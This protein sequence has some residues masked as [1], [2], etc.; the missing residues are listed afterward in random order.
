MTLV[1]INNFEAIIVNIFLPIMFKIKRIL[2][3]CILISNL[4]GKAL[5]GLVDCEACRAIQNA[6]SKPNL[7]NLISKDANL[8]F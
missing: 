3:E 6:L 7:V 5:R 4:S 1:K 2:G 8:V